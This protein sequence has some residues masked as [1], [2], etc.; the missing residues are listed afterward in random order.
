MKRQ[1]RLLYEG[2][3]IDRPV[4][5]I[6]LLLLVLAAAATGLPKFRLDASADSLLLESD[7]DLKAYRDLSKRYATRDFLFMTVTPTQAL[8]SADTI[9]LIRSLSAEIRQLPAVETVTTLL[10]VPLVKNIPGGLVK[11]ATHYRTLND[12]DVNHDRALEELTTS[13]LY[14]NVVVSADGKTTAVRIQ[15]K[16]RTRQALPHS[17][18]R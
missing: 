10:D 6:A 8:L 13:P 2:L 12:H 15:L 3:V 18:S 14:R 4:V 1:F 5:M 17:I 9:R 7:P 16:S 11:A